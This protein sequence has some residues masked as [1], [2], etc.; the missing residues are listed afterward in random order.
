MSCGC[1]FRFVLVAGCWWLRWVVVLPVLVGS[2]VAGAL[3]RGRL[4]FVSHSGGVGGHW[5]PA[6]VVPMAALP[7]P[8]VPGLPLISAGCSCSLAGGPCCVRSPVNGGSPWPRRG[9]GAGLPGVVF[10]LAWWWPVPVVVRL[11]LLGPVAGLGGLMSQFPSCEFCT[12]CPCSRLVG[13]LPPLVG[14]LFAFVGLWPPPLL[15]P[16]PLVAGPVLVEQR[17]LPLRPVQAVSCSFMGWV[18]P[19]WFF[20]EGGFASSFLCPLFAGACTSR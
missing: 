13:G 4:G 2:L 19:P 12:C 1:G 7:P 8:F 16:P 14:C 6:I 17:G 9:V 5:S 3:C 11:R 20:L 10:R 15:P 18:P